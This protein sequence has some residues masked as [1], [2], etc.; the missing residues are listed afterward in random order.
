MAIPN[1]S[2]ALSIVRLNSIADETPFLVCD[3][4]TI[5]RRYQ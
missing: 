5:E 2:P 1:W 4:E 3:L